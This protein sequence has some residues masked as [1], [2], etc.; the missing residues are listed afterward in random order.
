MNHAIEIDSTNTLAYFNRALLY[1]EIKDYN[2]SM[3]DLNRVLEEELGNALTLT[4]E[5]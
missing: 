3:A 2:A 4:T 5:A 1:Y